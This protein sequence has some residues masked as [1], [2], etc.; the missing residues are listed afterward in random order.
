MAIDLWRTRPYAW[1]SPISQM[2]D[3]MFEQ[4]FAPFFSN[5]ATGGGSS[6]FQTLPVNIWETGDAYH[7]A[8]MAPGVDEQSINVTVHENTLVIE[9]E[10]KFQAPEGAQPIWQEFGPTK[11]R[12]SL[13]LGAAVDPNAVQ[14]TYKNGVLFVT[15]PKA[16]HARPR[17]V[18]VQLGEPA[19]SKSKKLRSG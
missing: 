7:A 16:E 6:G 17:Q 9:G 5:T 19:E 10:L 13:Q 12:R 3:R 15:M 11:F 8:L 18:Q 14:A 4:A 1:T 2:V